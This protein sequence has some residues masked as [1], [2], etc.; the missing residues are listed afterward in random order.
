MASIAM[1]FI[2]ILLVLIFEAPQTKNRKE[3]RSEYRPFS[4]E[5]KPKMK[6]NAEFN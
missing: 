4:E 2:I 6:E 1:V 5:C 3:D